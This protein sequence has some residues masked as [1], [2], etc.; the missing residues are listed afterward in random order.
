[1][2]KPIS[3]QPDFLDAC[4]RTA[5]YLSR[6]TTQ[7]DVWAETGRVLVNFFG[8]DLGAFGTVRPDGEIIGEHWCFSKRFS[9]RKELDNDTREAIAEVLES[10]FLA[11]RVIFTPA[12]IS[13]AFL[14][15]MQKS[16]V[17]AVMLAGHESTETLPKELLNVYLAVAG[18]VGTTADRLASELEL[19]SHRR[20]LEQL[21][22]ERTAELVKA[23][24]LLQREI[25]ERKRAEEALRY[26]RDNLVSIF[27]AMED[28]VYII[29]GDGYIQYGNS[30]LEKDFGPYTGRRCF[31]YLNNC[32]EPCS[33]CRLGEVLTGKT[34]R[35]ERRF[36]RSEKIFDVIETPFKNREGV[37]KLTIFRD[38]TDRKLVEDALNESM[39]LLN[40][41]VEGTS[42]AIIATDAEGRFR[43]A[44]SAACRSIG[45]SPREVLGRDVSAIFPGEEAQT[46]MEI[47]Q[48]LMA[49][50]RT[51]TYEEEL[52]FKGERRTVM[53]TKGVL[54]EDNGKAA[55]IFVISRDITELKRSE[56][57]RLET[58]R[59]L[60]HTQKLESLGVL[61]GGI[62][63]DFNNLLAVILG[64]LDMTRLKVPEDSLAQRN[65]EKALQACRRSSKLIGQ[66]LDY[67]GKGL[68]APGDIDIDDLVRENAALFRTSVG[69]NIELSLAQAAGLPCVKADQNQ[70]QQVIMNLIINSAEAIGACPGEITITTGVMD[71]DDEYLGRSRVDVKPQAGR[72]VYLQVSDTGCGMNEESRA[73][74][75]EP[76]YTTKFMG[77]GLGMSAVLGIV[78]A[79]GGA[80]MLESDTGNGSVFRVLFPVSAEGRD[81]AHG[82]ATP[83]ATADI[84]DQL[85]GKILIVD[86]EET[87]LDMCMA[88]V[89]HLGFQAFSAA[90]GAAALRIFS[91]HA[92]EIKLVILDMTMPTMGGLTTLNELRRI[93]GDVN[94][95]LSSG[96]SEENVSGQ[97]TGDRPSGFIQKPFSVENLRDKISEVIGA[98]CHPDEKGCQ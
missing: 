9:G 42:D 22:K 40:A 31:E 6:L 82:V 91:E 48:S 71:C 26:D 38:I 56:A 16:R 77:R 19:R 20:H 30:A 32:M 52:T 53:T 98:V 76:F 69:R 58:E 5:Q 85:T 8:A 80:I 17:T 46:L 21:V 47:D 75:F 1:M 41:I 14:P 54:H 83:A 45:K 93:K 96:Y 28:D 7:E 15:I 74:I 27:E 65:I 43:L 24:E 94:V 63:H 2:E 23:N 49:E 78:K 70:I 97:F 87:V 18:L 35:Y 34:I 33:F 89:E 55:G 50:P 86:D 68:F 81:P 36:A 90:D 66:L 13:L 88:I 92:E 73:R 64:N 4:I 29:D 3:G 12:P 25:S 84:A 61:A 72:F 60:L 51:I 95:L 57:Q 39:E 59:R 11:F 37:S 67:A 62:A 44:N 10:G 79:H